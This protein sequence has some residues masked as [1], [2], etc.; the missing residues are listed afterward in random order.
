MRTSPP[1]CSPF[2]IPTHVTLPVLSVTVG[3]F[4]SPSLSLLSDF[5]TFWSLP[6]YHERLQHWLSFSQLISTSYVHNQSNILIS[7]ALNH[8]PYSH[9]HVLTVS[10]VQ[11]SRSVVSDSLQPHELQHARPPCPSPA[12]GVH[13]NS[14]PSSR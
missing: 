10:S 8:I 2:F 11:F 14:R 3:P 7:K 12:P 1:L 9:S 6:L 5:L 13:P 4:S